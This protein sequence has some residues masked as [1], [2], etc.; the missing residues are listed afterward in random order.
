MRTILKMADEDEVGDSSRDVL[1]NIRKAAKDLMRITLQCRVKAKQV[2][3]Q[4]IGGA[5]LPSL[6]ALKR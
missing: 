3:E 6:V 2:E 5:E 4:V 1:S